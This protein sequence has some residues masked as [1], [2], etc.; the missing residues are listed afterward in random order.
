MKPANELLAEFYI[1]WGIR[2]SDMENPEAKLRAM[3]HHYGRTIPGYPVGKEP[4]LWELE[5]QLLRDN[6]YSV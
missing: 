2:P 6:G 1:E 4:A 3:K 5:Q